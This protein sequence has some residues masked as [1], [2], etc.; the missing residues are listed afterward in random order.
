MPIYPINPYQSI[1]LINKSFMS[2]FLNEIEKLGVNLFELKP[3]FSLI[4]EMSERYCFPGEELAFVKAHFHGQVIFEDRN[5]SELQHKSIYDFMDKSIKENLDLLAFEF[6]KFVSFYPKCDI[7]F[8]LLPDV[9]PFIESMDRDEETGFAARS[10]Y[11]FFFGEEANNSNI[12][13]EF[14]AFAADKM[15]EIGHA[16]GISIEN[17]SL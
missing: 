2:Y 6:A 3:Q 12:L 11:G 5:I 10:F 14:Y 8:S 15:R 4:K 1:Q 9:E 17:I 16:W 7:F 13:F